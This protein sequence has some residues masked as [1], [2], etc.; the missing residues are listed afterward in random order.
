MDEAIYRRYRVVDRWRRRPE[1]PENLGLRE[2][3][4]ALLNQLNYTGG[5]Q[6]S[7]AL[8]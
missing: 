1:S 5:R 8:H 3:G 2:A 6:I 4:N 7:I